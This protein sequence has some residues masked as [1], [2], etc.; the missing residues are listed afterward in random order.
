M[1]DSDPVDTERDL[2]AGTH[3]AQEARGP[4]DQPGRRAGLTVAGSSDAPVISAA[5]LLGIRDAVTR[6]TDGGQVYRIGHG[7]SDGVFFAYVGIYPQQDAFFYFVGN[8][9]EGPV[10]AELQDAL[11]TLQR[12]IGAG[13][14]PKS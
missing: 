14:K 13:P 12:A 4:A 9:G 5:P 11:R 10:K 1:V 6:R 8:N 3:H 7:G 2:V